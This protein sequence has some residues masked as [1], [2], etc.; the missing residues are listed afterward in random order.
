MRVVHEY[1]TNP[2]RLSSVG[3]SRTLH[4]LSRWK[5]YA[6]LLLLTFGA[7][8]VHGYHPFAEDAEIYLPGVEKILHRE[9]F[10]VRS[11]F[12]LTQGSLTFFPN[13]IA[14]SVRATHLPLEFALF[15]W[16]V[17]SIFL[18]LLAS[19]ELAANLFP[20]ERARWGAVVLMASLLTLPVA[21]TA[22]YV[23]DQYINPRNIAAFAGL[24][25]VTRV[26]EQKYVRA[27][28][29]ASFAV[30]IH[31]LMGAFAVFLCLLWYVLEQFEL[32]SPVAAMAMFLPL[33]SFFA[34]SSP[35]YHE[36]A[37]FHGFH[38]IMNWQWYEW[39]GIVAPVPIFWWLARVAHRRRLHSLAAMCRALVIYDVIFFVAGLTFSVP[40]RFEAFARLQPLRSLHLLYM[41]LILIGGGFLADYVLKNRVWRWIALFLPLCAGMFYAQRD[42]FA[43]SNHIEW[44]WASPKNQWTQA[45][46]W[47]R[48]NTPVNSVF[49]VDPLYIKIPGEDTVGFRACAERSSLADGY[50]DSGTVSM[51]PPLADDW[52]EQFQAQKN[53]K[54]FNL[55]DFERLQQKYG[56][57]WFVLQSPGIA[58]MNCPYRNSAVVVCQLPQ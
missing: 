35:A 8:A 49:A 14:A 11:E 10:P 2:E 52:W 54:Q 36:A 30:A 3:F 21:G 23:M 29:W 25:A 48:Q 38:Y 17:V 51:F 18:L 46:L 56:A 55:A 1:L 58:G 5:I 6:G 37:R 7:L 34:P 13:L 43:A 44:P 12:F 19:W 39:L 42:L 32:R 50:K 31:P 57:N 9:L 15:L 40:K 45:F 27:A 53:W 41:L 26:L 16:Q 4:T 22:L 24:F 33:K 20:T 47:I 28:L